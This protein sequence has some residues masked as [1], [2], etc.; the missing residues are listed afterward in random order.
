METL[1]AMDP[2][3]PMCRILL[4]DIGNVGNNN[5]NRKRS[6]QLE[7]KDKESPEPK[8]FRAASDSGDSGFESSSGDDENVFQYSGKR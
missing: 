2:T 1:T 3:A 7:D 5:N 8:R 6:F 4:R